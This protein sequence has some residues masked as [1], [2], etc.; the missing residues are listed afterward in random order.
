MA[1]EPAAAAPAG[2]PED[3]WLTAR[4]EETRRLAIG[5][6]RQL[7]GGIQQGLVPAGELLALDRLESKLANRERIERVRSRTKT[8][9]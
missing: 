9:Q 3:V 4:S 6:K 5:L 1:D 2:A 7:A 8:R